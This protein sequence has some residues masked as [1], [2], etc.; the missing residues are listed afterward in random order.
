MCPQNNQY[1]E[2]FYQM[3]TKVNIDPQDNPLLYM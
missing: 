2:F 3:F 1:N